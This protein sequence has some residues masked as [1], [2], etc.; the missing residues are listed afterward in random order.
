MSLIILILSRDVLILSRDFPYHMVE[1]GVCFSLCY[2]VLLILLL[3][4][5]NDCKSLTLTLW[6]E[7]GHSLLGSR[8]DTYPRASPKGVD[9]GYVS[10]ATRWRIQDAALQSL[11]AVHHRAR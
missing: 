10:Q 7:W 6:P 5:L 1:K 8:A 4:C 9:G 3:L 11:C 2:Y